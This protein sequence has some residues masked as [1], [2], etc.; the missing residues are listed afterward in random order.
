MKDADEGEAGSA[1]SE[2]TVK[3]ATAAASNLLIKAEIEPARSL[4]KRHPGAHHQALN[5]IFLELYY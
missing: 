4:Q 3:A 1:T 5:C 2:E